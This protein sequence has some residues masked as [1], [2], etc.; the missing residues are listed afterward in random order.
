MNNM[1]TGSAFAIRKQVASDV[2]RPEYHFLPPSNWMNDPNGLIQWKGQYHLFYQHNPYGTFH[3]KIHWGHAV[4]SDLVHWTDLSVALT[5]TPGR[6]DADGCWSGCAVNNHGV[7]TLIYSGLSPQVVCLATSTD[8]LLTW[9]YY[10]GNPVVK[11]PPIES[12]AGTN[13]HFR[14]PFVWHEGDFW[15]ML[16]GSNI[17]GVGGIILLYRSPYLIQWDYL[18]PLLTGD[19]AITQPFWAGVMWECPNFLTFGDQRVLLFSVQDAEGKLLYS[20]YFIGTFQDEHFLPHTQGKLVHG[21]YF[22]APQV[23]RDDQGRYIMRGWLME[24]RSASL[25]QEARWAGVMSLPI[26]VALLP[27]DKLSLEPVPELTALRETHWH[28]E[29]IELDKAKNIQLDDSPDNCL[30]ILAECEP[31]QQ[32]E[33]GFLLMCSPDSQE[34]TRLIYQA[35]SKQVS[36]ERGQS[37]VISEVDRENCSATIETTK[38]E[39]VKFHIFLDHSVLEVFVNSTCYLASR[40]YPSSLQSIGR[41]LFVRS[42]MMRVKSLDIWRIASI[43]KMQTDNVLGYTSTDQ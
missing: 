19:A 25:M 41:E 12:L 14:D 17:E 6:A 8:D 40:I 26:L 37:S 24:G 36:I 23:L 42:G 21:G 15:Y 31:D 28:Y 22:Y 32:C 35:A 2:H 4:S 10:S 39:V 30:E 20:L 38:N 5:P 9:Q 33:F 43:W 27:N 16:M 34:Q 3:A 13:G 18:H 11:G 1:N 29:G 7:P